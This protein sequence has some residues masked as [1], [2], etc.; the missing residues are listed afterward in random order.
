MAYFEKP[1]ANLPDGTGPPDIVQ[2]KVLLV[3]DNLDLLGLAIDILQILGH[4]VIGAN[5]AEEALDALRLAPDIQV[6]ISDVMMP[7]M[8]GIELGRQAR[9]LYPRLLVLLVSG[10]ADL[11]AAEVRSNDFDFLP[12]P[13]RI[14]DVETYLA[15]S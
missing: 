1:V 5:N 10:R 15:R 6:L 12:K 4:E 8:S 13:Y 9:L 2:R 11:V 14:A 3:D 7:G